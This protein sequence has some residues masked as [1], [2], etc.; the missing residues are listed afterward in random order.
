MAGDGPAIRLQ[1]LAK[2]FGRTKA[3]DGVSFDV[4]PNTLFG[5][6]GPNGAGKTT[7]FSL[8]AGFLKPTCGRVEV[9]GV[10]VERISELRGRLSIL[11]QD[12][13]FESNVPVFEQLVFYRRL[14]GRSGKEALDDALRSL[15]LVGLADSAKKNPRALSHGMAKRLGIAQAFLGD[16]EVILLDEP[17]AG[18]DPASAKAIREL[19]RKLRTTATLVISSHDLREIQEM[20]SHVAILNE[21]RLVECST[22]AALTQAATRV[23]MAFARPLSEAE[24][25]AVRGVAGVTGIDSAGDD[26]Y[27]LRMDAAAAGRAGEEILAEVVGRLVATLAVPR[28]I[29]EGESLEAH[30]I[31]VTG[32]KADIRPSRLPGG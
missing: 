12:A 25:T 23:R 21:G 31:E 8:V 28:S 4:P 19:I 18:L 6:L 13:A 32:A 29:E 9:L 30:F 5:L 11:P 10:D 24:M 27:V 7:L 17:T 22:V 15:E 26:R 16:P 14:A 1:G 20:C 3:L 2:H